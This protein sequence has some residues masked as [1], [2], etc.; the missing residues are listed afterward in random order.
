MS[1]F[2]L[3]FTNFRVENNIPVRTRWKEIVRN[4]GLPW[5]DNRVS[6]PNYL[7]DILSSVF[8]FSPPGNGLDC[9]RHWECL[10]AGAIP[11]VQSSLLNELFDGLPVMI[12]NDPSEITY[13]KLYEF[14]SNYKTKNYNNEKKYST[15]WVNKI[16]SLKKENE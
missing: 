8:V 15:Y 13:H 1:H 9:H 4:L 6:F 14:L 12:V 3:D 16:L 5:I 11:I 7:D 10:L 2:E